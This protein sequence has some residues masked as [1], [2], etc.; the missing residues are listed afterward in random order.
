M[1]CTI[2]GAKCPAVT[3]SR[4]MVARMS[5]GS[6]AVLSTTVAP[7]R[8]KFICSIL[9]PRWNSGITISALSVGRMP[10]SQLSIRVASAIA[11]WLIITPLEPPVVPLVYIM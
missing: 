4:S 6:N 8:L 10:D 11:A 7:I 5:S 1:R 9:P 3:F 2:S